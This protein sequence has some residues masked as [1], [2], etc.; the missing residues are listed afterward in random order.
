LGKLWQ[1][2]NIAA[3]SAFGFSDEDHRLFKEEIFDFDVD[4]LIYSCPG[5]KEGLDQQPALAPLFVGL[6]DE[7]LLF[8]SRETLDYSLA[9]L[10]A[11]NA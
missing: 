10:H 1:D 3:L 4:E 9:R 11:L 5:L 2:W 7:A 6:L 8:V